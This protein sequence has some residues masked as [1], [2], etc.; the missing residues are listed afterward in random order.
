MQYKPFPFL[1][2]PQGTVVLIDSDM[3]VTEPEPC[4]GACGA[5]KICAF[6][7]PD[8]DTW[9]AA[10]GLPCA[11]RKQT[12][13][14][15]GFVAFSAS[16]WPEFL[17]Q[18]WKACER[19]RKRLIYQEGVAKL[20]PKGSGAQ[21]AP[22]AVLMS[23]IPADALSLL[24]F[25]EQ[26]FPYTSS[27]TFVRKTPAHSI[28]RNSYA[29]T[30]AAQR[31]SLS[32]GCLSALPSPPADSTRGRFESSGTSS[33]DL[34]EEGVAPDLAYYGIAFENLFKSRA[35]ALADRLGFKTQLTGF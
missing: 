21:D 18:W 2:R 13:V 31:P 3:I 5:G 35:A 28:A 14:I 32:E 10:R 17:A 15:A 33:Q 22:N 29:K 9:W 11:P 4:A 30:L 6:P 1:L 8:H 24:P 19:I 12:Y 25:D 34:A 20:S 7:D 26:V 27:G 23:V 16:F